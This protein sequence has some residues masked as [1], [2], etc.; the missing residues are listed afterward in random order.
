M[1]LEQ[2][3][4]ARLAEV[5][6]VTDLVSN[7]VYANTYPDGQ[8]LPG[9]VYQL[10][11][12]VPIDSNLN[13]DGGKLQSRIQFTLL[14]DSVSTTVSLENAVKLAFTRYQATIASTTIIDS[15]LE[16]VFDQ[17]YDLETEQT[18]RIVDYLI[19]WE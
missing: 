11:S 17:S 15:R 16:N 18:A 7:R 19:Y 13:S 5:S 1:S 9:I 2:A 4:I 6:E 14:S 10:I 3:I 12:S 8:P